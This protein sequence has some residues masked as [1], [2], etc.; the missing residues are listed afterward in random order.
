MSKQET[1]PNCGTKFPS[2]YLEAARIAGSKGG[3]KSKRKDMGADSE[4]QK[5]AQGGRKKGEK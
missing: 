4:G 3:K 1:C 5:K 2:E